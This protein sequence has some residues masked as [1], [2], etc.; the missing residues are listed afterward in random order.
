M[1]IFFP[2]LFVESMIVAQ[3]LIA[4]PSA[5]SAI[6]YTLVPQRSERLLAVSTP[7]PGI[8]NSAVAVE[9]SATVIVVGLKTIVEIV[10]VLQGLL[11]SIVI[12]VAVGEKEVVAPWPWPLSIEIVLAIETV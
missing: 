8:S 10:V 3:L 6:A 5:L 11:T 9:P 4:V 7:S 12:E 2:L 1:I